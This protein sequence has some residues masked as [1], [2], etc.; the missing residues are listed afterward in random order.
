MPA[1]LVTITA[2][3]KE[4]LSARIQ[5]KN[6]AQAKAQALE[7]LRLQRGQGKKPVPAKIVVTAVKLDL[8]E[9]ILKTDTPPR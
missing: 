9:W 3:R 2:G 5:A 1:Y 8:P 4:V 6:K 7:T